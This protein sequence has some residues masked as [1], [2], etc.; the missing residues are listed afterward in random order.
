MAQSTIDLMNCMAMGSRSPD[1][2]WANDPDNF[3]VDD[4]QVIHPVPWPDGTCAKL[5]CTSKV[6]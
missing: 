1:G 4:Q 2:S 5:A 6:E 3:P